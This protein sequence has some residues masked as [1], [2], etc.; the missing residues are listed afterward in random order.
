LRLLIGFTAIESSH[1][2]LLLIEHTLMVR[3]HADLT[4]GRLGRRGYTY[5]HVK[6]A[7]PRHKRARC[8]G[9][10]AGLSH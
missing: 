1:V 4:T 5:V 9:C 8:A 6:E 7:V 10:C 3:K 2:G